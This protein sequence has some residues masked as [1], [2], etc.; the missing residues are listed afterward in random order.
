MTGLAVRA[1]ILCLG[2][3]AP[4]ALAQSTLNNDN[5]KKL[6]DVGVY[7]D[8]TKLQFAKINLHGVGGRVSFN[9]RPAIALEAEMAYDFQQSVTQSFTSSGI[10]NI[11]TSQVRLIHGLAGPKIQAT[12]GPVQFF[13]VLKGG[14]MNFGV[15]GPAAA[16]TFA[17]QVSTIKD[18]DTK[19]V[20]YPGGGIQFNIGIFGV[21]VEAGDEIFFDNG[22][23]HN[24]KLMAGPV[25]RF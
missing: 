1:L 21:R 15:S 18:G 13:A 23:N 17:T 25:L 3:I 4:A 22:P 5:D 24:F 11:F 9:I 7:F 14:V 2:L 20:F 19:G 12:K 6:G 8:W 10:T 16:G